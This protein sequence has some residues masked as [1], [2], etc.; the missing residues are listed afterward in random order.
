MPNE[1]KLGWWRFACHFASLVCEGQDVSAH[2]GHTA[3][4][5]NWK[6]VSTIKS[7]WGYLSDD[8]LDDCISHQGLLGDGMIDGSL[9]VI[10]CI[11]NLPSVFS[12][13]MQ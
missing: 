11:L 9:G 8:L 4:Q 2:Q 5:N 7:E 3:E 12:L 6:R 1:L 13:V 10:L